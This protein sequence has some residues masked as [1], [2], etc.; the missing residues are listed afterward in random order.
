MRSR[1]QKVWSQTLRVILFVQHSPSPSHRTALRC[2]LGGFQ[3]VPYRSNFVT[4]RGGAYFFLPGLRGL[5]YLAALGADGKDD[6]HG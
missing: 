4:V 5:R 2:F 6:R 1:Q 3:L